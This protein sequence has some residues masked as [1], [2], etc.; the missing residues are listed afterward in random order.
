MS[1]GI[2]AHG[3]RTA[4][5]L[6]GLDELEFA[7]SGLA[8]DRERAVPATGKGVTIESRGIDPS[9]DFQSGKDFAIIRAHDN[10]PLWPSATDEQTAI[11]NV[12]RHADRR[13]A[14]QG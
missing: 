6:D 7:R 8:R 11:H 10:Q 14:R 2:D 4:W 1:C 3:P 12:H 9:P 13:A 5:S